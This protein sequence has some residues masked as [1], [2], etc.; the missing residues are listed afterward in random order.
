MSTLSGRF[1]FGPTKIRERHD[2]SGERRNRSSYNVSRTNRS[3]LIVRF[4]SVVMTKY[5]HPPLFQ[6]GF[7]LVGSC[8][9]FFFN[10]LPRRQFVSGSHFGCMST[11]NLFPSTFV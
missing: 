11:A 10:S 3:K 4:R 1:V 2:I 6:P 9:V 8:D 5:P 7:I